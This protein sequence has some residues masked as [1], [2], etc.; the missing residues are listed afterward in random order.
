MT[1]KVLHLSLHNQQD[2][3]LPQVILLSGKTCQVQDISLKVQDSNDGPYRSIISTSFSPPT[4]LSFATNR[5]A[6]CYSPGT[7]A[8]AGIF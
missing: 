7:K 1:C 8:L 6:N 2:H 4:S 5:P 3:A